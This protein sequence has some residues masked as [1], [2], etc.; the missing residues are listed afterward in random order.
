MLELQFTRL[1]SKEEKKT[2]YMLM[3]LMKMI[4]LGKIPIARSLTRM[5]TPKI[6]MKEVMVTIRIR[7]T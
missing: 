1:Q 6:N 3:A 4:I 2:P 5:P 7:W